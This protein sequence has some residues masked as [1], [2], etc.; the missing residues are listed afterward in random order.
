VQQRQ[1][2]QQSE[3]NG[4]DQQKDKET[5]EEVVVAGDFLHIPQRL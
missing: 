2:A 4:V 1:K 5:M 3:T